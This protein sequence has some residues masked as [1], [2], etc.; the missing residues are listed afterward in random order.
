VSSRLGRAAALAFGLLLPLGLSATA[1]ACPYCASGGVSKGVASLV[2]AVMVLPF[3]VSGMVL[4]VVLR[5]SSDLELK[6]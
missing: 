6:E 5:T 3:V 4:R 1:W 2:M